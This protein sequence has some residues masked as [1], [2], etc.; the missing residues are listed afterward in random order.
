MKVRLAALSLALLAAAGTAHADEAPPQRHYFGLQVGG[1]SPFALTYRYR[2]GG[3]VLLDVGGF[4]A[5]EAVALA[6]AGL[7][8]ELRRSDRWVVYTGAGGSANVLGSD[9]IVFVYGRAGLALRLGDWRQH[10]LSLDAGAWWG[11]RSRG[12]AATGMTVSTERFL[13]PMAG[14]AYLVGFGG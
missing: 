5:P 7:V 10:Q 1:T 4:G 8:V 12:D 6:T 13:I 14:L 9:G 2:F 3:P 11:A